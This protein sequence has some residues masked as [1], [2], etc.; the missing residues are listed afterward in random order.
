MTE[1]R[2]S[3]HRFHSPPVFET[4]LAIQF[5]ELEAFR[6]THFGLFYERLAS[7]FPIVEDHPR[8]EPIIE[9]FP[10]RPRQIRFGI[11]ELR[12][13]A[14]VF[15]R[16]KQDGALLLQLQPDRFGLNWRRASRNERC[17]DF[18]Q[19]G[20]IF[21]AEFAEFA[22]FCEEKGLGALRPNLCE[23]V[24]VN[25]I[26]PSSDESVIECMENV[27]ANVKLTHC[28]NNLPNPELAAFHRVYPIADQKG[29][30]YAE[31]GLGCHE[32]EGDFVALKI[33]ARI[34]H[35]D[36]EDVADN[37]QLAHDFVVNGFV[38]VTTKEARLTR[39]GQNQ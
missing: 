9:R 10:Q 31:A 6:A 15:F 39:W 29:R 7:R 8:A 5:D 13:P 20:P 35:K 16:D 24:Y 11:K 33:A 3:G 19:N 28:D 1:L 18:S 2:S 37:I 12:G 27:L 32:E 17:P 38:A 22:R 25:H 36:G 26:F 14:R 23:V 4:A 21:V 34:L 30:W